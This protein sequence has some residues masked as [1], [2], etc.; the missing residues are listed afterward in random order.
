[1]WFL[2]TCLLSGAWAQ[3]ADDTP[4]DQRKTRDA[5]AAEAPAEAPPPATEADPAEAEAPPDVNDRKARPDDDD[6]DDD[7][8]EAMAALLAAQGERLD[9]LQQELVRTKLAVLGS[10]DGMSVTMEGHFRVRAN[11]Y[12][13]LFAS[14]TQGK[15]YLGDARNM[16]SRLRL[17]PVFDYK[18]LASLNTELDF[19]DGMLW[20][21]NQQLASTSLFAGDPSSTGLD[22]QEVVPV[23]LR[24]VWTS[25]SIPV[26]RFQF[27]RQANTW[28]MGLLANDGDGFDVSFGE[29]RYGTISDRVLFAT[30]PI[31]IAQALAGKE[32]SG[33]PLY[34]VLAVDRLVEDPLHQYYGFQCT[35][36]L[37]ASDPD[38]NRR[39]DSDGDGI[40][41]ADHSWDDDT[42]TGDQRNQDWWADQN[43]DVKQMIYVLVYRG[44]D[45][46]LL[47]TNGDLTAGAWVVHR[48]QPETESSVLII[49]AY[50]KSLWRSVLVE[51]E[52]ISIRGDTRAIL[53]PSSEGKDPLAKTANIAGYV[54]RAGVD[55]AS[56]SAVLET[57]YAS[58]DDNVADKD[59][60]GRPLHPDH[61]V[62]LLL[63][64][65]V[66]SRVTQQVWTESADGLW[67]KGG[68]YNSRYI[69]PLVT[70]SPL[71]NVEILAGW[72]MAWPD[73]PDGAVI[74]CR[75]SDSVGCDAPSSQQATTGPLG[76]EADLGVKLRWHE[77]MLISM[78]TGIAKAT[79]RLPLEGAGLNPKGNFF[80][81]QSRV[82]WEF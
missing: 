21:D 39:C 58:G 75:N 69:F 19:F 55:R 67:S 43:D 22:G 47:G 80:T 17:R 41:D 9:A 10:D 11:M 4:V 31:A 56:W 61:N 66:L 51:F 34:A 23:R 8:L 12:N 65:E 30:K 68:V 81:V 70:V 13:H 32:D 24:R 36:G 38:F 49:D 2:A 7:E 14:Q 37:S 3:D 54:G 79:D 45:V 18:G 82:A 74:R 40:T 1:M 77:H 48:T 33:I 72:L 73:K 64:E 44:E 57:G 42:R 52:G 46:N 76:W 53:L 59:F 50:W 26:G 6:D 29:K 28:G 16:E 78:E 62:G 20:G 27:G 5:T 15:T 71:D 25:F 63:Y 35:P 60:T